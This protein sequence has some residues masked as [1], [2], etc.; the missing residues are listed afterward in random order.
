MY[1]SLRSTQDDE[2]FGGI[3]LSDSVYHSER[4]GIPVP[5][6]N[7]IA[8]VRPNNFLS[9][10]DLSSLRR[11][12]TQDLAEFLKTSSPDD[13]RT[14]LKVS[15]SDELLSSSSR[16]KSFK[17]L[18]ASASKWK[19]TQVKEPLCPKSPTQ[20]PDSVLA[21][22]TSRGKPY[23]QIQV[24]YAKT[25][26]QLIDQSNEAEDLGCG[27]TVNILA[28][29]NFRN[30]IVA[31]S[32]ITG[33]DSTMVSPRP[34]SLDDRPKLSPAPWNSSDR[35]LDADIVETYNQ[36]LNAER[37]SDALYESIDGKA[38]SLSI[39]AVGGERARLIEE[40]TLG[41]G[42]E[43]LP[44]LPRSRARSSVDAG[45][46]DLTD[47]NGHNGGNST[48][49][50]FSSLE[51]QRESLASSTQSTVCDRHLDYDD[52]AQHT[53]RRYSK[54]APPPRPGPPPTR[55]LPS[56]P[57]VHGAAL[58]GQAHISDARVSLIS[59]TRSVGSTAGSEFSEKSG[60]HHMT[61]TETLNSETRS[62]E[63]RVRAKKTRDVQQVR[64]HRVSKQ[65]EGV[66]MADTNSRAQLAT[67]ISRGNRKAIHCKN[68]NGQN[69][70]S[71]IAGDIN[72]LPARRSLSE[73]RTSNGAPTPPQSPSMPADSHRVA[74]LPA[75]I[76]SPTLSSTQSFLS[77][78]EQA[79]EA[80]VHAV[81][82][83]NRMLEQALIAVIRGAIGH[84]QRRAELH[85]VNALEDLLKELR[86]IDINP[87]D[88]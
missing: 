47:H 12:N 26:Y 64:P 71:R 17:F 31:R 30:S 68:Q 20:L 22:T 5:Q 69:H 8:H 74:T 38:R 11:S 1:K 76:P 16:K 82:K 60:A 61:D 57:E 45:S 32:S 49:K 72:A 85:R 67:E 24:D 6:T 77:E 3:D 81:E 75:N 78:K 66:S 79:L 59:S 86:I 33:I 84:D 37:E 2:Y 53:H 36:F 23:L 7:Q 40:D 19:D 41:T 55:S 29:F 88:R 18:R 35:V 28:R 87:T 27:D 21:R 43:L 46:Q 63:E 25:Y 9:V 44:D 54:K 34:S 73:P 65:Q 13:Y 10:D 39:E 80:R 48:L 42:L 70:H 58:I 83:K 56:L 51:C 50:C 14:P 4:R 52:P 62:R 15:S